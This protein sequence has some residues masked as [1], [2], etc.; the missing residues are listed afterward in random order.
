MHGLFLLVK[1]FIGYFY[2]LLFFAASSVIFINE[3]AD[4]RLERLLTF[5]REFGR[6]IVGVLMNV[7]LCRMLKRSMEGAF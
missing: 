5:L 1:P 7:T 4:F 3:A 6:K 2:R